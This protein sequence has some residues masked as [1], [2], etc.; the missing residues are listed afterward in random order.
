MPGGESAPGKHAAI[1]NL[2]GGRPVGI[3]L[4]QGHIS[5]TPSPLDSQTLPKYLPQEPENSQWESVL[6]L[7]T[8]FLV[9]L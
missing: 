4:F 2:R 9:K 6:F 1:A 7:Q 5:N 3:V 8:F